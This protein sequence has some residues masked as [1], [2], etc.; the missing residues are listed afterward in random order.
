MIAFPCVFLSDLV[1]RR[2]GLGTDPLSTA[3]I[4][5]AIVTAAVTV[6]HVYLRVRGME[7]R[8][9][10]AIGSA[11]VILA[12]FFAGLAAAP[13]GGFAS[14]Y[15]F[16]LVPMLMVW[17]LYMPGGA[18]EAATPIVGGFFAYHLALAAR[19]VSFLEPRALAITVFQVIGVATGVAAAE[20]VERWRRRS[21]TAAMTDWLTGLMSRRSLLERLDLLREKRRRDPSP[22]AVVMIDLD[23][24]KEIND[25]YGHVAG[26]EVLRLVAS[27][28]RAATR[29]NDLSCRYGGDEFVLVLDDC[30]GEQALEVVERLRERVARTPILLRG[31]TLSV[32]LSA[33]VHAVQDADVPDADALL[34]SAD[35]ALYASKNAGRNRA[36]LSPKAAG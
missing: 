28:V 20:M 3:A 19:H 32:T 4:R 16:G 5:V 7:A 31:A 6:G 12:S 26:D 29:N 1:L 11:L 25:T 14:P 23:G 22:L 18:R 30:G 17:S 2:A 27:A 33:G 8:H 36:S 13:T 9:P 10:Y 15:A 34:R 24:F 21:A 35:A